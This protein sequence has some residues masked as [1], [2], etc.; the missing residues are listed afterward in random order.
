MKQT[1]II[2]ALSVLF[3]SPVSQAA[4]FQDDFESGTL[5]QW[6]IGGRQEGRESIAEVTSY[7]GSQMGHVYQ[8]GA[9]EINIS[10]TLDY[11]SDLNFSFDMEILTYTGTSDPDSDWYASAG[12]NFYFLDSN[13][14]ELGHV[15]VGC[16]T[17]IWPTDLLNAQPNKHVFQN[18]VGFAHYSLNVEDLL[19]NITIDQNA[20]AYVAIRFGAYASAD[21]NNMNANVWVDNV[22]VTPR[23]LIG[24]EIEGLDA[25]AENSSTNYKAIV[26]YDIGNPKDVTASADW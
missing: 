12:A 15:K 3:T 1:I 7:Q 24:L 22:V 5:D 17:A 18:D 11:Q 10:K 9:T 16:A 23:T 6:T 2:L 19:S 8:D 4:I 25:V 14:N 13:F 21:I 20:L 26:Y